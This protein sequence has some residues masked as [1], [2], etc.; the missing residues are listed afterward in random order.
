MILLAN[1]L[2]LTEIK[3]AHTDYPIHE[4]LQKRWSPRAY[5]PQPVEPEKL[6][7]VLEAARW[8]A[9]GGNL[10]PWSFI[11]ATQ[12]EQPE[13]FA[14]LVGCLMEGNVPWASQAPVLGIAVA[15]LFRD[16]DRLNRHAF[17]DVGLA[18]QNLVVQ[19]TALD[20]YVHM[21]GGFSPEKARTA[22]AI[23]EEH[24]AVTMFTVGYLGD[25]TALP[26]TVRARELAQRVRRPLTEFIFTERWGETSPLVKR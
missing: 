15:K 19:A 9:S 8:S 17:H 1:V 16:P 10:Q 7:S 18:L 26:E 22:F 2:D 25:L 3:S 4:L 14:R 24:E 11:I 12:A 6:Q 13:A 20:L 23:P 5:A 21:M